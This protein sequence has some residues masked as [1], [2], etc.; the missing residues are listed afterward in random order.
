MPAKGMAFGGD[1]AVLQPFGSSHGGSFHRLSLRG[2][3]ASPVEGKRSVIEELHPFFHAFAQKGGSL[4]IAGFLCPHQCNAVKGA[5]AREKLVRGLFYGDG[6][7]RQGR[8]VRI[9]ET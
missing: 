2:L 8:A 6:R 5:A 4:F 1:A 7:V 3:V 9:Y